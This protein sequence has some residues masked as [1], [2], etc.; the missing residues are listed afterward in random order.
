[1]IDLNGVGNELIKF[2]QSLAQGGLWAEAQ[3]EIIVV[4]T[5]IVYREACFNYKF[6][7]HKMIS[8]KLILALSDFIWALI[9]SLRVPNWA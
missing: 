1:M 4:L 7:A 9:E 2:F 8:Q 5:V 6:S 3:V